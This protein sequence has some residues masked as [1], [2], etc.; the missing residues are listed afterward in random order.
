MLKIKYSIYL[1]VL[2]LNIKMI[3]SLPFDGPCRYDCLDDEKRCATLHDGSK[4]EFPECWVVDPACR[5]FKDIISY[6]DGP[7]Y[8]LFRPRPWGHQSFLPQQWG[9]SFRPRPRGYPSF[10]APLPFF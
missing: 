2:L 9:P 8:Q 3:T 7:C 5:W 1:A 10:F 6:T 4:Q